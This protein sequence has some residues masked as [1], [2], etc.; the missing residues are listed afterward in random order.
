MKCFIV[1]LFSIQF[2]QYASAL[3]Q[4]ELYDHSAYWPAFC[5]VTEPF[6]SE[7]GLITK[8]TRGVL[9]RLVDSGTHA[10]VD[11][12]RQ[13]ICTVPVAETDISERAL[14]IMS[15]SRVKRYPNAVE[16]LGSRIVRVSAG[17]MQRLSM[18]DYVAIKGF[19]CVRLSDDEKMWEALADWYHQGYEMLAESGHLL[20]LF[21]E[22]DGSTEPAVYEKTQQYGIE[23]VSFLYSFLSKS[24][25]TMLW[26]GVDVI[27][28]ELS[29][30][31]IDAEGYLLD[32][33][34]S[35]LPCL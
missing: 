24:Y 2:L 8:D 32:S 20:L 29:Y 5:S 11:F 27:E 33:G 28:G 1:F 35:S 25:Q 31:R 18:D 14:Q 4:K 16:L 23:P 21:V 10:L 22:G 6:D 34:G 12:G 7:R 9:I 15:G 26:S 3:S 17:Q 30:I 13:G 19:Y